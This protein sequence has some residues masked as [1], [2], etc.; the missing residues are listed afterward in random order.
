METIN[1]RRLTEWGVIEPGEF[2][3]LPGG[4]RDVVIAFATATPTPIFIKHDGKT[5][6]LGMVTGVVE[7]RFRVEGDVEITPT[8][9]DNVSYRTQDGQITALQWPADTY[10]TWASDMEP[11]QRNLQEEWVQ[12]QSMQNAQRRA[13]QLSRAA[14]ADRQRASKLLGEATELLKNAKGDVNT[15]AGAD[16]KGGT[17]GKS[18]EKSAGDKSA[19]K[20]DGKDDKSGS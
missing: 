7:F 4:P 6:P 12:F 3:S 19:T 13:E 1:L 16:D 14:E 9:E 2:L 10:E 15:K 11:V 20:D 5:F 18:A 17:G 8:T